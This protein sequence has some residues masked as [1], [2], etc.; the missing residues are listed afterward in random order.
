MVAA[1]LLLVFQ[2]AALPAVPVEMVLVLLAPVVPLLAAFLGLLRSL[3]FF[4]L[5]SWPFCFPL[6][7]PHEGGGAAAAF[8]APPSPSRDVGI[9]RSQR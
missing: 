9:D 3:P 1:I 4:P 8:A 6:P 5:R 2:A 7:L